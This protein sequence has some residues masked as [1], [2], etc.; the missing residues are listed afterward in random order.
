MFI[1]A[2]SLSGGY[3]IKMYFPGYPISGYL[4]KKFGEDAVLDVVI[5]ILCLVFAL[6]LVVTMRGKERKY[7]RWALLFIASIFV[8]FALDFFTI[9][10]GA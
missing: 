7:L 4:V 9:I 5:L 10:W 1:F 3:N 6:G 8:L 2:R